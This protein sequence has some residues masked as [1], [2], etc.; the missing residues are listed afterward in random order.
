MAAA[1]MHGKRRASRA[2]R[3]EQGVAL[4]VALV[5][6]VIIGLTSASVMR[7]ALSSDLVA[8]N[9]R[10]Q[11]LAAQAAHIAL[12]FCEADLVAGGANITVL[13]MS[14]PPAFE[15]LDNWDDPN[16]ASTMTADYMQSADSTFAPTFRPQC[17]AQQMD[18]TGDGIYTPGSDAIQFTARGFSPDYAADANG[19]TDSGSVVWVQSLVV[20]N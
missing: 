5:V 2:H 11:T 4:I 12:R 10:T 14:N 16:M 3:R 13:P 1:S 15:N 17:M 18:L 6:L 9:A 20:A 19:N 8:N 7:G